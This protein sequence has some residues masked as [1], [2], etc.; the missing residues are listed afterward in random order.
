MA[1]IFEA[2]WYSEYVIKLFMHLTIP[3]SL[4]M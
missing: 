1:Q 2:F 4:D 3:N